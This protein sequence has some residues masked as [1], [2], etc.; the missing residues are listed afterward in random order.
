MRLV[1]VVG[2]RMQI[3]KKLLEH[4]AVPRYAAGFRV[5]DA[6]TMEA[7]IQAAGTARMEIE[8]RLSKVGAGWAGRVW[9]GAGRGEMGQATR[10]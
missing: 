10:L 6:V 3:N 9:G 2:A 5:T 1:L 8:A 4:G 7:A